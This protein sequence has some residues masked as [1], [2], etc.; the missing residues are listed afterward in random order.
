MVGTRS[1]CCSV[2]DALRKQLDRE[3]TIQDVYAALF[4]D[5]S[6]NDLIV[7]D[8]V[9]TLSAGRSPLVLTGRTDDLDY[10]AEQLRRICSHTFILRGGMGAQQRRKLAESLAVAAVPPDELVN[11]GAGGQNRTGYAR[12]FRAALY[13]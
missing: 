1:C 4:S 11:Y 8:L 2:V 7:H 3:A 9:Q 5:Q 10:L 13:R 6:R 12:L